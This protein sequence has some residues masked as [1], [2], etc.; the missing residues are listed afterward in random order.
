LRRH[1]RIACRDE[2]MR[3]LKPGGIALIR[4]V[5]VDDEWETELMKKSPSDEMNSSIWPETGK[6]QKNFSEKELTEFYSMC[7]TVALEKRRKAAF[8][9]GKEFTATNWWLIIK[10]YA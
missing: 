2:M 7:E 6:F 1:D 9:A 10:K 4:V 3:T 8:K 5:S